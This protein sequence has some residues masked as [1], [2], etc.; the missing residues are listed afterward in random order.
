MVILA[1]GRSERFGSDKLLYKIS[2][3]PILRMVYENIMEL[4]F[5][6]ALSVHTSSQGRRLKKITGLDDVEVIVDDAGLNIGGPAAGIITATKR[7]KPRY[8]LSL[9]GDM[10]FLKSS[11]LEKFIEKAISS[12][13]SATSVMYDDGSVEVLIQLHHVEWLHKR[14]DPLLMLRGP[15]MRAG[16][17]LRFAPDLAL[18]SAGELSEKRWEFKNIDV[19]EDIKASGPEISARKKTLIRISDIAWLGAKRERDG[20]YSAAATIYDRE[21]RHYLSKNVGTLAS[22][23]LQDS[24]RCQLLST[25]LRDFR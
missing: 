19:P 4:G 11:T 20:R 13:V 5:R 2:E 9:P 17:L 8:L 1:G 7:L 16:D 15:S 24:W 12:E 6:T 10:P 23:A 21:A 3:K 22:H 14:S 25:G 18:I